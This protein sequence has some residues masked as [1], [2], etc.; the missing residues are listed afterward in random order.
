LTQRK[1]K[2]DRHNRSRLKEDFKQLNVIIMQEKNENLLRTDSVNP[3]EKNENLLRTED[4]IS[5]EQLE[6]RLEMTHPAPKCNIII[7]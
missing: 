2:K 6:E 7:H 3:Q 5:I 4:V 1:I